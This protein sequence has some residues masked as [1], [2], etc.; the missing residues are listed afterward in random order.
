MLTYED[1]FVL[2]APTWSILASNREIVS[3][4]GQKPGWAAWLGATCI[5]FL[6]VANTVQATHVCGLLVTEAGGSVELSAA[7]ANGALCLTCLMAQSAA[8]AIVFLGLFPTP[9][10]SAVV[11]PPQVRLRSLLHSFRLYVRPPP[12]F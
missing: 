7:S 12:S 5:L 2:V 1:S 8:A 11:R 6:L 10:R 3:F 9:L 4:R